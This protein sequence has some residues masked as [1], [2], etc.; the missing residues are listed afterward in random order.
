M[1]KETDW[2]KFRREFMQGKANF[3]GYY[4]CQECKKWIQL[5]HLHH[6]KTRGSHPELALEPS[7]II[8]LCDKCHR[9]KHNQVEA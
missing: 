2:L 6:I 9:S 8:L 5:P 4:V 1:V 3:Q 7:N